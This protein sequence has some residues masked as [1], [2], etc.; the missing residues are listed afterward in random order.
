MAQVNATPFYPKILSAR[1]KIKSSLGKIFQWEDGDSKPAIRGAILL[2]F[3]VAAFVVLKTIRDSLFL[4]IYPARLLPRYMAWNTLVST[5][6]AFSLLAVYKVVSLRRLLQAAL[7]LFFVSILI[8]WEGL[9]GHIHVKPTTFYVWT[10]VYG[11]IITVQAWSLVST[12]LSARQGK[13]TLG[14][15][16]SGAILGGIAGGMLARTL[17]EEWGLQSLF[18][19]AALLIAIAFFACP[20]ASGSL[21]ESTPPAAP[22]QPGKTKSRI[23]YALLLL[24]IVA[25][26][27]IVSTFLDFQF[28]AYTQREYQS[29]KALA[30][31]IGSFYAVLG[32]ASLI[33]QLFITPFLLKRL[34]LA[35]GMAAMPL[36]LLLGSSAVYLRKTFAAVV[37]LRGSEELL[38]HS[39]DRSS[40]EALLMAIPAHHKIRLKSLV[41][42]IGNRAAEL[43]GCLILIWLFTGGDWPLTTLTM[44]NMG[45]TF[46]W[47]LCAL[48]LGL[49]EYP[50]LLREELRREELN[51]ETIRENLLSDEFYRMLPALLRNAK[52][53]TILSV[54]DLLETSEKNRIGRYLTSIH[55]PDP[56]V[57]LKT[58][59][60]L[61]F[62]RAD[63]RSQVKRLTAD[64]D[65][66]VRVEAVHYLCLRSRSPRQVVKQ[67]QKDEELAVRVAAF[68]PG[69]KAGSTTDCEELESL[70]KIAEEQ[71]HEFALQEL[72]HVIQFVA[73][74]DFTVRIYKRLLSNA[75]D[76]VRKAALRSIGYTRPQILIPILL[77]LTRVPALKADVRATLSRYGKSLIPNLEEII[78]NPGESI[79]RRKLALK[80]AADVGGAAIL[81]SVLKV[82]KDISI[83]LRFSALKT[84][85]YFRKNGILKSDHPALL[86]IV[87]SEIS[88]L[89]SE[90][91]RPILFAPE[92]DRLLAT[93][94]KQRIS[95]SYERVFRA[96]GL[97]LPPDAVYHSYL[98][99]SSGESRQRDAALEFLEHTLPADL[100]DRLLP[101]LENGEEALVEN[102]RADRNKSFLSLL[103]EK[104]SL[105]ISATIQELDE[106]ELKEWTPEIQKLQEGPG[107]RLIE[108]TLQRR[109]EAMENKE[110][111]SLTTIQK[112]EKLAKIDLFS[113]LSPSELLL[114]SEA[115]TEVEYEP[116]DIIY[117]EGD[118]AQEIYNL[119]DG[120]VE[121]LRGEESIRTGAPGESFGTLEVL[122]NKKRMYTAV[123]MEK[124]QC[125]RIQGETFWEIL[126]DYSPVC[127]GVI[128]VLVQQIQELTEKVSG[129][130]VEKVKE[131]EGV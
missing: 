44:L 7:L 69:L 130:R 33:F 126:E 103:N 21:T 123:A 70:L 104:D 94:F 34:G 101:L 47:F 30:F 40:F 16:G 5:G 12:Q 31:F 51:L 13:R 25:A 45:L 83:S 125:L 96:L 85:N 56:E 117:K 108:E 131:V 59:Q 107:G 19:C 105:L 27:T 3:I 87:Y 2:F 4:S 65:P 58:L 86:P 60:L 28:K 119:I 110:N 22:A 1:Q 80:I 93:L 114:L 64:P 111:Q 95:W 72:A 43:L 129:K 97:I 91:E 73:P 71:R 29:E 6:V 112:M 106:K 66:R 113:R 128:E 90:L 39:L 54:L 18:P 53:E 68:A 118:P 24:M 46:L 14:F 11:T 124:S 89:E 50:K 99:W 121:M 127:H 15:I 120:R 49:R 57:R 76:E 102:N 115:A 17:A 32:V 122:S 74:N 26:S 10:G 84:L 98:G 48:W 37:T 92:K 23:R 100:R 109:L 62:Q 36:L 79:P 88:I 9:P 8:V 38:R 81:D 35:G 67:F 61:F 116:E 75:S 82:A 63:L 78:L 77:K 52:K 55:H 20:A 41:E 42:T